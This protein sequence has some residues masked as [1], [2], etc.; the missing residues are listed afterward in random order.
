MIFSPAIRLIYLWIFSPGAPE[1]GEVDLDG[2]LASLKE[3]AD[4]GNPMPTCISSEVGRLTNTPSSR[5]LRRLQSPSL[6]PQTVQRSPL[7]L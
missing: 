3:K 2:L 6:S 4:V 7:G 5:V 1:S